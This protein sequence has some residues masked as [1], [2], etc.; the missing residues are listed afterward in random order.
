MRCS[1]SVISGQHACALVITQTEQ[2]IQTR[3]PVPEPAASFI[4]AGQEAMAAAYWA[5]TYW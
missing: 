1:A 4:L 2:R 3:R 5:L